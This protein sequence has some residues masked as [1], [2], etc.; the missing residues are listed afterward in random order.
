MYDKDGVYTGQGVNQPLVG[1]LN[2]EYFYGIEND[3]GQ[4]HKLTTAKQI[5]PILQDD[6]LEAAITQSM[7]CPW[8]VNSMPGKGGLEFRSLPSPFAYLRRYQ[9]MQ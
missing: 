3:Y 4:K 2:H 7:K 6:V 5:N 8:M 1:C 9:R